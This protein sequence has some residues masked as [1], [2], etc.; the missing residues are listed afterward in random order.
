MSCTDRLAMKLIAHFTFS[1]I[2]LLIGDGFASRPALRHHQGMSGLADRF[3]A[4][5]LDQWGVLHDG[6]V[7]YPDVIRTL[8]RLKGAGKKLIMLSNSSKRKASSIRGLAQVGIDP[9]FFFDNDVVTSG[10]V[11]WQQLSRAGGGAEAY[12]RTG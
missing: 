1:C 9:L 11:C 5:I 10:E 2:L 4:F 12:I 6:K 8:Q 3:D 7:L